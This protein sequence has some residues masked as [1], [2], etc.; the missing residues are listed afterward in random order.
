MYLHIRA[1]TN[2]TNNNC[3]PQFYEHNGYFFVTIVYKSYD[4]ARLR[5]TGKRFF[6]FFARSSVDF[7]SRRNSTAAGAPNTS[8][9]SPPAAPK[10]FRPYTSVYAL[11]V[12]VALYYIRTTQRLNLKKICS[13]IYMNLYLPRCLININYNYIVKTFSRLKTAVFFHMITHK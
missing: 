13:H 2:T 10:S 7:P 3:A 8:R 12:H 4:A 5:K 6:L 9:R 11:A 1:S